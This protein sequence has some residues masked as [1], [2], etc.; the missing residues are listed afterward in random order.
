MSSQPLG[1]KSESECSFYLPCRCVRSTRLG[2]QVCNARLPLAIASDVLRRSGIIRAPRHGLRHQASLKV[3]PPTMWHA[4]VGDTR[5]QILPSVV[6]HQ[7]ALEWR[8]P[9]G[10]Q[11]GAPTCRC[12]NSSLSEQSVGLL[13]VHG[14]IHSLVVLVFI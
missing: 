9:I 6:L 2:R 14:T 8:C 7:R 4:A 5:C 3:R 1:H 11:S 13:V 10:Q 12:R